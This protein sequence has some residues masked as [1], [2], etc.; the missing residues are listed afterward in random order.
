MSVGVGFCVYDCVTEGKIFKYIKGKLKLFS[1]Y[2]SFCAQTLR[3]KSER[4]KSLFMLIVDI[5]FI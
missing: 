2:I 5:N 3:V 1:A 4:V